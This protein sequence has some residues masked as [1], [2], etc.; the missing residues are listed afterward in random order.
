MTGVWPWLAVAGAGALHGL[1]PA[2]G[3]A[4]VA[5]GG[6]ARDARAGAW[7]ALAPVAIGHAASVA[8]IVA[9]AALGLMAQRGV[10]PWLAGALAVLAATVHWTGHLPR[11]LDAM[12]GQAG[13]AL[14]SFTMG[15]AHGTGL[16]LVPALI[17]LCLSGSPAR[18]ITALGSPAL[19]LAAVGVHILAL[20][21]MTGVM[22]VLARRGRGLVD[23]VAKHLG[24]LPAMR[25]PAR[26]VWRRLQLGLG[27]ASGSRSTAGAGSSA[28]KP[29]RE[30]R[31]LQWLAP[32]ASVCVR[33][34]RIPREA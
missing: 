34:R 14:W 16:M 20:L 22:A 32:P 6:H 25:W 13:V 18:E 4:F 15:M 7:R 28:D 19:A 33:S 30:K 17:P 3:W 31:K 10:L 26:R 23:V 21:T 9:L 1:N 29:S 24:P 27:L 12:A 8:A 11:S 2:S 5:A